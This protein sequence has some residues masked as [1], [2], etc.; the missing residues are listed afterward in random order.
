VEAR[1]ERDS[2]QTHIVFGSRTPPRSA[3][4]RYPLS[5]LSAAFGGG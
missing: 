5:L 1:V 3:P 4:E 2:A